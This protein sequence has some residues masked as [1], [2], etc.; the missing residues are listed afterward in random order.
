MAGKEEEMVFCHKLK[1]CFPLRLPSS[2]G[3]IGGVAESTLVQV[4]INRPTPTN[5]TSYPNI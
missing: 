1:C 4:P 5:Q 3:V 2:A